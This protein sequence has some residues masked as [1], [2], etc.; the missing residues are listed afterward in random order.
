MNNALYR[1]RKLDSVA[2]DYNV[3]AVCDSDLH[4]YS[5]R[6]LDKG[7]VALL[8]HRHLNDFIIPLSIDEYH[9]VG[10]QFQV[11]PQQYMFLVQV[12]LPCSNHLITVYR[13]YMEK[14][15]DIYNMYSPLGSHLSG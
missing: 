6:K 4:L 10:N 8:W 15:Y 9:I 3:H 13:E 1:K 5:K 12:Y 2:S 7:G 14:L 11:T